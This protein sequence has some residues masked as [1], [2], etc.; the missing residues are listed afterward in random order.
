MEEPGTING[1]QYPLWSQFVEQ[2]E[3]W[4]GGLLKSWEDGHE[5]E[6]TIT[7]ISLE[8]NGKDSAFFRIVAE[9]FDCG[10]DVGNG[11]I[12]SRSREKNGITFEGYGGHV[13]HI[14]EPMSSEP[15]MAGDEPINARAAR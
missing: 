1:K 15:F 10:F 4:I 5:F 13:F 7:G 11:G 9:D 2:E 3:R 14:S 6:S 12:S 8:P